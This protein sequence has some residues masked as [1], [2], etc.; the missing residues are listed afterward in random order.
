VVLERVRAEST[1]DYRCGAEQRA[2]CQERLQAVFLAFFF[3][4]C[5]RFLP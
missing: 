5:G 3:G 1:E 2:D 4:L